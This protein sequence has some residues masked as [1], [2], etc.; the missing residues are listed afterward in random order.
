MKPKGGSEMDE[1][2]YHKLERWGWECPKCKG[3][4]E[5]EDD[6]GYHETIICNHIRCGGEFIPVPERGDG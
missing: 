5:I 4:N 2:E 3:W 1:V 6:P